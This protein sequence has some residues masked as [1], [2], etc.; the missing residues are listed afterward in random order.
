MKQRI[1]DIAD[2]RSG[3]QFREKVEHDPSGSVLVIQIK[4]LTSDFQLQ[5]HDLIRVSMPS[6]EPYRVQQ[7]DV[8]FLARGHR[9]GATVVNEPVRGTIATG[10]FFI[11]RPSPRIRPGYLAWAINQKGFRERLRPLVRGSHI[12]LITKGDFESLMLDV[13]P[14]DI[15]QL[16]EAIDS[17]HRRENALMQLIQQKRSRLT[18]AA[19]AKAATRAHTNRKG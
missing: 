18:D 3:Y 15:Q 14:L 6:P 19:C 11:L 12:P 10:F 13:P 17:L 9:L 1:G 16:I 2:V 5:T 8:L 7:G 4:D